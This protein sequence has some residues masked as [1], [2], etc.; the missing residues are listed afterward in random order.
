MNAKEDVLKSEESLLIVPVPALVAVLIHHENEK[1]APLTEEEVLS[2][3]D[4]VDSIAMPLSAKQK[5][6]ETRGYADIDP[7]NVW[8]EWQIA[9][10]ETHDLE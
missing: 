10:R 8:A 3:R 6:E 4:S 9:R 7:E 1:G 5:L 2:I